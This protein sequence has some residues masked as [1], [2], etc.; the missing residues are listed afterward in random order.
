MTSVE[1]R[2]I[3]H[4]FGN[5][6]ALQGVD[7]QI[8]ANQYV[9]L[10]GSS[11]CGKTTLLR[12]IAGLQEPTQGSVFFDH[13]CLDLVAPRNR[14]LAMVF[15]HPVLYP[16]F[17]V[18]QIIRFG[19][20]SSGGE[21]MKNLTRATEVA[22]EI[23]G[24]SDW[25]DRYP[26][27]LSG[28]QLRRVAMAKAMASGQP[29]RLLDEPLSALDAEASHAIEQDFL[30]WHHAVGGT[31]IHVTHDGDEAMRLADQI[32]VMHRGEIIQMDSPDTLYHHPKSIEVALS[33]GSLPINL[34]QATFKNNHLQL[35]C[36]EVEPVGDWSG[37]LS[38]FDH[39]PA[40]I[41]LGV[42]PENLRPN[43]TLNDQLDELQPGEQP[44]LRL[45][46]E[47][48]HQQGVGPS[49]QWTWRLACPT[50]R[51]AGHPTVL[52]LVNSKSRLSAHHFFVAPE[53]I[54][55]FDTTTGLAITL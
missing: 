36:R 25:L 1:L 51:R 35:A 24:I 23:T 7:W 15:Q 41:T 2:Q 30:S 55:W 12:V 47:G 20:K 16:H 6:P 28:G 50:G 17:T 9:V 38:R 43:E 21:G 46:A 31:T 53:D 14:P 29:L 54:L 45:L 32:A 5:T 44:W 8:D 3:H 48:A 34:F 39:L 26:D 19:Q 10:L 52:A 13:Q 49:S 37:F 40:L 33:V 18:H 42:R 11:G 22:I 4:H 27:Q